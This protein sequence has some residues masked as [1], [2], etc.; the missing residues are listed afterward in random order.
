[1]FFVNVASK[2]SLIEAFKQVKIVAVASRTIEF[3]QIV[4]E[5]APAFCSI[6]IAAFRYPICGNGLRW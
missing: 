5:A 1:V 4:A 3:T 2:E 6:W